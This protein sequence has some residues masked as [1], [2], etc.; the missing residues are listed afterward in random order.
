MIWW[1]CHPR[2]FLMFTFTRVNKLLIKTLIWMNVSTKDSLFSSK[3]IIRME[4]ISSGTIWQMRIVLIVRRNVWTRKMYHMLFVQ[5]ILQTY[6][7]LAQSKY[8][9]L[10]LNEKRMRTLGKQKIWICGLDESEG[11]V[12]RTWS[13][14]VPKH[15]WGCQKKA[16]NDM[17]RR[18]VFSFMDKAFCSISH[19]L[20]NEKQTRSLSRKIMER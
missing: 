9:G 13:T 6:P 10:C 3:S 12:K 15:D 18:I 8:L 2:V 14:N 17:V 7:K 1:P 11:E 4:I 16:S 19:A 20:A 5:I